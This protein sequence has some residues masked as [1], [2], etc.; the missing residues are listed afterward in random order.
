MQMKIAAAAQGADINLNEDWY[1]PEPPRAMQAHDILQ[2][3]IG[4]GYESRP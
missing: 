3:G 4:L 1:N 2:S